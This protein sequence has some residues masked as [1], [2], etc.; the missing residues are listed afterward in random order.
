MDGHVERPGP[1]IPDGV[2]AKVPAEERILR[3]KYLDWC[4][5]RVADRFLA[6]TPEQIYDLAHRPEARDERF[7]V[8]GADLESSTAVGGGP[9]E[10]GGSMEGSGPT[11]AGGRPAGPVRV[12]G[13]A[14]ET[15]S[16]EAVVDYRTLVT[17]VTEALAS[18]LGLPSFEAW[19]AAYAAD[20]AQYEA[21]LLGLWRE[22]T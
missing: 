9:T 22:E 16:G 11:A 15:D 12:G 21:E 10:G 5:A 14:P 8:E 19:R 13:P 17:R 1:L 20:P 3:A 6:L 7:A 18:G 4:S 2:M